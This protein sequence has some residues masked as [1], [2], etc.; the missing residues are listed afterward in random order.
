M[1]RRGTARKGVRTD[2]RDGSQDSAA[3]ISRLQV[4]GSKE[5]ADWVR[6]KI[7]EIL[8][9]SDSLVVRKG[10]V[11]ECLTNH[12][13]IHLCF[14]DYSDGNQQPTKQQIRGKVIELWR[15]SGACHPRPAERRVKTNQKQEQWRGKLSYREHST[16]STVG[17]MHGRCVGVRGMR[18][19]DSC[20][21]M[22]S[23]PPYDMG[24]VNTS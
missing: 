5:G 4:Q 3:E 7:L 8:G 24:S 20:V 17:T 18:T 16:H 15:T 6:G 10:S 11:P 19:L 23:L 1:G 14:D 21:C 13:G 2:S 9:V 22:P 12:N